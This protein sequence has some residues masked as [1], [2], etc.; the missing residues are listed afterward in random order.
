MTADELRD[1]L[2]DFRSRATTIDGAV[3][4]GETSVDAALELLH[5]RNDGVRWSAIRI[6]SE[7]GDAR[8][9]DPLIAL[10]ERGSNTVDAADALKALTGQDHGEDTNAW[11]NAVS[12]DENSDTG[13]SDAMLI[14]AAI[15]DLPVALSGGSDGQYLAE[16]SL[17]DRRTQKVWVDFSTQDAD[18]DAIVQLST[19]CGPANPEH[20]DWA[21]KT[22][23][24]LSYGAI[25]IADVEGSE[26]FAMV[27][28]YP[29]A[30]VDAQDIAKSLMALASHADSIEA[31][32]TQQ[33]EH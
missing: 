2:R 8:A 16:V 6:L 7:I 23:M 32:L 21:L 30:T 20:F 3:A 26:M 15:N 12:G 33:D 17:S 19:A 25:G 31:S 1:G 28:A 5:D 10:I 11:R 29:R 22:N 14:R 13:G 4:D 9:V 18:G 24:R 27:D